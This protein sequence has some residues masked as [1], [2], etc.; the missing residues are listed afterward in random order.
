FALALIGT[1]IIIPTNAAVIYT[2]LALMD[3]QIGLFTNSVTVTNGT[4]NTIAAVRLLIENLPGDV[5]VY[6]LSGTTTN[7]IP[8]V[9]YTFPLPAGAIMNFTIEYYRANREAFLAP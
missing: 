6:N 1:G 5:Q 7:G 8:Y 4:P 9:Q 2:S 3:P